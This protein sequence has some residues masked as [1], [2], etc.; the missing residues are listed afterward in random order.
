M[1]QGGQ[2]KGKSYAGKNPF[3]KYRTR[4]INGLINYFRYIPC[5]EVGDVLTYLVSEKVVVVLAVVLL[6]G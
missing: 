4:A 5:V 2:L 3:S 6:V 1:G